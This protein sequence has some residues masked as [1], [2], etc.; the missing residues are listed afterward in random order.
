MKNEVVFVQNKIAKCESI[1]WIKEKIE[2]H[3]CQ[4]WSV[5]LTFKQA[6]LRVDGTL[7]ILSSS[8][9]DKA[10]KYFLS[11][12]NKAVYKNSYRRFGKKLIVVDF[13]EGGS[14]E[15]QAKHERLSL[16]QI[17]NKLKNRHRHLLIEKPESMSDEEFRA[18]ICSNWNICDWSNSQIYIEPVRSLDAAL[19]YNMKTGGDALVIQNSNF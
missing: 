1:K 4:M 11:R 18:L 14:A 5:G 13:Q 9:S 17:N 2:S 10:V 6:L 16:E 19:I 12:L 8:E 7:A 15:T 3:E